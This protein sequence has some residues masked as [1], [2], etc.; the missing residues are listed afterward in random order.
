[1]E[2]ILLVISF[3]FVWILGIISGW[4]AHDRFVQKAVRGAIHELQENVENSR[5]RITIEEHNGML[6]AYE[7]G[8]NQ[9]MAQGKTKQEL[10]DQL[11]QKFP[12]TMFAALPNEVDLLRK[13]G[14]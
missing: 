2:L 4:N 6:F 12:D 11:R 9:F 7:Y 1:M 10:E 5:V 14:L 3:A 8:T 13:M